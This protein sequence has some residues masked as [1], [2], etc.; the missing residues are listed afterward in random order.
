M[1]FYDNFYNE[2]CQDT[3]E[4]AKT[5]RLMRRGVHLANMEQTIQTIGQWGGDDLPPEIAPDFIENIITRD[6]VCGCVVVDDEIAFGRV[7]PEGERTKGGTWKF[8][9]VTFFDGSKKGHIPSDQIVLIRN[10]SKTMPCLELPD[11]ANTFSEIDLSLDYNLQNSRLAPIPVVRDGKAQT[12]MSNILNAIRKGSNYMPFISRKD[13]ATGQDGANV[14][15]LTDVSASDKIQNLSK[16]YDD[17][18][19]RFYTRYGIPLQLINQGSNT[20][21]AE[22]H[23]MDRLATAVPLDMRLCRQS[24]CDEIKEKF[25]KDITWE[26]RET[27]LWILKM[28]DEPTDEPADET[29]DEPA[30]TTAEGENADE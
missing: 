7:V 8:Y 16:L 27:H 10:N 18:Q 23:S 11:F 20:L 4:K 13:I 5:K 1:I 21:N 22:V 12:V 29:A 26:F 17:Y 15:N 3:N 25:D 14:L 19:K 24:A 6:G 2:Y 30:D 28:N 9:N